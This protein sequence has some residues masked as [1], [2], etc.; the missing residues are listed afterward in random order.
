M[1][2]VFPILLMA[3]TCAGCERLAPRQTP[4]AAYQNW[5]DRL[6]AR[7]GLPL[8]GFRSPCTHWVEDKH[9]GYYAFLPTDQCYKMEPRRRWK[10]LWRDDF[11]GSQFCPVPAKTCT[12]VPLDQRRQPQIWFDFANPLPVEYRREHIGAVYAVDFIGRL[13]SYRGAY[14]HMGMSDQEMIVDRMIAMEEVEPPRKN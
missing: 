12:F 11:E 4:A 13:T 5:K 14:G 7:T 9:G 6:V 1:K 10:G 2:L 8:F 3:L